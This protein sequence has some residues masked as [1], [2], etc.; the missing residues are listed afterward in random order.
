MR[1]VM[2][3]SAMS[4]QP[5]APWQKDQAKDEGKSKSKAQDKPKTKDKP[6]ND[7]ASK[8][9]NYKG[10]V[11]QEFQDKD[12]KGKGEDKGQAKDKGQSNLIFVGSKEGMRRAV[13]RRAIERNEVMQRAMSHDL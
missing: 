4:R 1:K 13:E 2:K 5:A 9:K 3:C 6:K 7:K 8:S 12:Y 11:S 10:T